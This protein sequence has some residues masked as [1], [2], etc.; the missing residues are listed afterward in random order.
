[1]SFSINQIILVG[2]VT[3]EPELKY[4]PAGKP[5]LTF[6]MATNRRVK[7][8][9]EWK[10]VPTFHKIVVWGNFAEWLSKNIATGQPVTVRGRVDNRS[11]QDS[12]GAKKYIS[13]VVA[14]DVIPFA[15]RSNHEAAA[16]KPEE[17][18]I[19]DVLPTEEVSNVATNEIPF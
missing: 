9:E 13:E 5:V 6:S 2:N 8:G 11:Y 18:Q 10:D 16:K 1:M 14:D 3:K 4:T 7:N 12:S 17:V 19:D 15:S